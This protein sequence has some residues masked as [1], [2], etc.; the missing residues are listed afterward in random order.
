MRKDGPQNVFFGAPVELCPNGGMPYQGSS[1][2]PDH[3]AYQ[4]R[5]IANVELCPTKSHASIRY[6]DNVRHVEEAEG[7]RG[8]SESHGRRTCRMNDGKRFDPK[9]PERERPSQTNFLPNLNRVSGDRHPCGLRCV[10]R[11]GRACGKSPCMVWVRVSYQNSLGCDRTQPVQPI[12]PAIDHDCCAGV[13]HE[14][15]AMTLVSARSRV[16]LPACS[17][18]REPDS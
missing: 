12:G 7:S 4:C 6:R 17:Q 3:R 2:A 9:S 13:L 5:S 16:D 10:N 1:P 18:K 15:R 8:D 11:T 14:E